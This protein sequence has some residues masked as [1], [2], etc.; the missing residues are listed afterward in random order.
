MKGRRANG[1]GSVYEFIQKIK[2]DNTNLEICEI[3]KSC[4]NK[5]LC[6]NREDCKKL[7]DK[8]KNCTACLK[9]CD[10]Y[11]I[12]ERHVSQ[13]TKKDGTRTSPQYAK[14]KKDAAKNNLDT[15][16]K[17]SDNTFVDKSLTTLYQIAEYIVEDRHNKN[18]TNDNSYIANL[19]KLNRLKQHSFMH[20]PAQKVTEQ[21]IHNYLNY[22]TNYSDSVIGKDFGL[23]NA[24][25]VRAVRKKV[26][27][28]NPFDDKDEFS[29]PVSKFKAEKVRAFTLSEQRKF[30]QS[31]KTVNKNNKYRQAWL[32]MLSVGARPGEIYALSLDDLDFETK[33][34]H[35][36]N[37]L[38][39]D[40]NGNT[41]LGDKTKTYSGDRFIDMDRDTETILNEILKDLPVNEHKL[42]FWNINKN[43]FMSIS[44]S[45]SAFKRFC[46][47]N[48]IGKGT[49]ETQ[50]VLRHSFATRK[51][52]AGMP[53]EVLKN[54]LGHKDIS[55]TLNTYF[56]AFAEYKNK[57]NKKSE[58]YNRQ[59]KI[60]YTDLSKAELVSI[61]LS[62]L[63]ILINTPYLD[64]LD[65]K[66]LL[67][68]LNRIKNKYCLLN[69]KT[70]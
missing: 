54:I 8:C 44:A 11:Y 25:F 15:I 34:I 48:N 68:A 29:K 53:P 58:D 4:T 41:I 47:K 37:S 40:K 39:K 5:D 67:E 50:Y 2:K 22:M 24:T 3:C 66:I 13:A 18:K 7:C 52:E 33:K 30:L 70:C 9:Y 23:L 16:S 20:K 14:K 46:N 27:P 21:E 65:K 55:V 51:I 59:Q 28:L 69:E 36:H 26:I 42:L 61:E 32:L 60:T 31:I 19:A 35:I 45:N 57:Y 43:T 49:D 63:E 17:I 1:E 10:R 38:T 6:N 64:D 62:K 56:D 12:Y